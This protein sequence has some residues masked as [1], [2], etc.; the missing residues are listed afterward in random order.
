MGASNRNL[1]RHIISRFPSLY[2]LSHTRTHARPLQF[3]KV[4]LTLMGVAFLLWLFGW[5]PGVMF[6]LFIVISSTGK[7]RVLSWFKGL[8]PASA[9]AAPPTTDVEAGGAKSSWFGVGGSKASGNGAPAAAA[10]TP[11][12]A[13]PAPAAVPAAAT[14][15][16]AA[17]APAAPAPAAAKTGGGWFGGGK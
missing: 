3:D 1:S 2:S 14:A 16:A 7:N 12:V 9:A 11:A 17:A 10:A 13:A 8:M 5:L 15:T 4:S 6:A